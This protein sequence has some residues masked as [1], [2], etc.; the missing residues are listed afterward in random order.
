MNTERPIREWY[1]MLPEPER[2]EANAARDRA[3]AR[4]DNHYSRCKTAYDLAEAIDGF[5]WEIDGGDYDKWQ[6]I[7][8]RAKAGK[9]I[10]PPEVDRLRARVA[11]LEGALLSTAASLIAATSLLESGGKKAAWSDKAFVQMMKDYEAT[12]EKARTILNKKT[13]SHEQANQS[14]ATRHL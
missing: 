4:G 5:D 3:E 1:D 7:H 11:E 10:T 8:R 14:T 12:A 9:S 2:T 6:A 13:L